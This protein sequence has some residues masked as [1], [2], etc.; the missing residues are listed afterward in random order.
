MKT[1]YRG[2]IYNETIAKG[3]GGL[4]GKHSDNLGIVAKK[5][6]HRCAGTRG[7]TSYWKE[8]VM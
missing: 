4:H 5:D 2:F 7:G 8:A 6:H 1:I 3:V